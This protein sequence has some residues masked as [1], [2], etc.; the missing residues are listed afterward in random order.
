MIVGGDFNCLLRSG[1]K[2]GPS[3]FHYTIGSREM[4]EWITSS[5][6]HELQFIGPAFTWC[7]SLSIEQT[8]TLI[9]KV[10]ELNSTLGRLNTWWRQ[11]AKVRWLTEGDS[12]TAYFHSMASNRRR[13]NRIHQVGDSTGNLTE[14]PAAIEAAFVQF[15]EQ[16]W[17]DHSPSL[18]GWPSLAAKLVLSDLTQQ[19]LLRPVTEEDIWD[20]IKTMK[21]NRSPGADGITSSFLKHFWALVKTDVCR[22]II[23]FFTLGVMDP[24]WKETIVV[25]LPKTPNATSPEQFRPI[26]LCPIFYKIVAKILVGRLQHI[27]PSFIS[28][29]QGAFVPGRQISHQYFLAQEI[30][31]KFRFSTAK[32]GFMA[33]K[34]DMSQAYDKMCWATLLK[35]LQD[36][37]FPQQSARGFRQGCPLSPYL[38]ILCSELLSLAFQQLG[39]EL[40]VTLSTPGP[41]ISHLLYADDILIFS[42]ASIAGATK[43]GEILHSYCSWTGQCINATKSFVLFNNATPQWKKAR[44]TR[45]LDFPRVE[46]FTYLGIKLALRK[47]VKADYADLIRKTH[48]KIQ[49]WGSRH[50][51]LVGRAV[52]I[53]HS[54]LASTAFIMSHS[55]V[56]KSVLDALELAARSFLWQRSANNRGLHYVDWASLC[57]PKNC[58]GL[59][60]HATASWSGPLRARFALEY[61]QPQHSLFIRAMHGRYSADLFSCPSRRSDSAVIKLL[62]TGA[63]SLLSISRWQIG[64]G[65]A[66]NILT[67]RWLQDRIIV[68]WPTFVNCQA[69]DSLMLAE[70]LTDVGEWDRPK[71]LQFFGPSLVDSIMQTPLFLTLG[72]DVLELNYQFSGRV[73]N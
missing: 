14:D 7:N 73:D 23:E 6:L 61:L 57:R 55:L 19:S 17:L 11:R 10:K 37:G 56:P 4:D 53:N 52:L 9:L 26:S 68:R 38:F 64:T 50:L 58:G 8:K 69:L 3:A 35:L 29:E 13:G 72:R 67:G 12:N 34:I 47:L 24:S 60:F 40:G 43:V 31:H 51:S 25:L 41:C 36:L 16:K 20:A 65:R 27:L 42:E 63:A 48:S 28:E 30:L 45:L 22:A 59:G 46:E 70:L 54:L 32:A 66:V 18:D 2:S 39:P 71:L 49:A 33:L 5:G 21:A 15:F 62:R 44:L 1:D